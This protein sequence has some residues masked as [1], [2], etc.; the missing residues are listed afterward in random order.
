MDYWRREK[1]EADPQERG[2]MGPN[3]PSH[4]NRFLDFKP[5]HYLSFAF[6]EFSSVL[7]IKW[8]QNHGY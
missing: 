4:H 1:Q 5:P 6:I 7:N 3:F 2:K 8:R